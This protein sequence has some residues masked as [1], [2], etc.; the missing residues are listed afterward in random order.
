MPILEVETAPHTDTLDSDIHKLGEELH[1]LSQRRRPV[2]LT[3]NWV[4][5]EILKRCLEDEAFKVQLF[6]FIDVLP[7]LRTPTQIVRVLRE[8]FS[9]EA[10]PESIRVAIGMLP[11]NRISAEVVAAF[12]RRQAR[13]FARQ[14]MVSDTVSGSLRPLKTLWDH[15]RAFSVDL[16]GEEAVSEQEADQYCQRYV[17]ALTVLDGSIHTWAPQ[18]MLDNDQHGALPRTNIS[19]KLSSLYSQLDPI[20]PQGSFC[21]VAPPLR[22]ILRTAQAIPAA[23]TIDMET[24]QL[25]DLVLDIVQRIFTEDEFSPYPYAGVAIQAYLKDS[26]HDLR[27]LIDWVSQRGQPFHIR[28]VKGAYWDYEQIVA[29][30]RSWPTPVFER[31]SDTD[32]NFEKLTTVLLDHTDVLRPAI[33]SHNVRSIAHAVVSAQQRGLPAHAY[34]IQMLYGIAN[35]LK[36]ALRHIN[37]RLRE[38]APIGDL[39]QGMRI[40]SDDCSKTLQTSPFSTNSSAQLTT[41]I[42]FFSIRHA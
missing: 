1:R 27:N 35:P 15:G 41:L 37:V 24:Y 10:I 6:Q 39:L 38:Y 12:I 9:D 36:G 25:K 31:K 26:E 20:S 13:S 7:S 17:D 21:G 19:V 5:D 28:L 22:A 33:G 3:K 18:P 30:Q 11:Q 40:L 23:V 16:L 32:A 14:F 4:Q 29:A 2:V 8:Y 42:R 34:E